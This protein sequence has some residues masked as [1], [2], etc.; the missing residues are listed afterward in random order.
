MNMIIESTTSVAVQFAE[1][2]P[3]ISGSDVTEW[4]E[5]AR[6]DRVGEVCVRFM[7]LDEARMLNRQFKEIDKPTNVLAFQSD[8]Q[9]MLGDLAICVPLAVQEAQEQGK[10]L[11]SH[12]AHLVIHGTLH[13]CGLDHQ[14][15]QEARRMESLESDLMQRLGFP[16]PYQ[17]YG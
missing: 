2:V 14:N 1:Q 15:E 3:D 17:D 4:V 5:S 16:N 8:V 11:S 12:V 10:A 6:G 13:L 9:G 7:G